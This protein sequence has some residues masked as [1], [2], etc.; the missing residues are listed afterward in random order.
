MTAVAV[1]CSAWLAVIGWSDEVSFLHFLVVG[2]TAFGILA[3]VKAMLD[4][5]HR[6]HLFGMGFN[7][8]ELPGVA[9]AV[10]AVIAGYGWLELLKLRCQ[11]FVV[12]LKL[13]YLGRKFR[14]LALE[15]RNL[16]L[17]HREMLGLDSRGAVLLDDFVDEGE[18]IKAHNEG[19][20]K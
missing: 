5:Q 9:V 20:A 10:R 15:N 17:Q 13:F 1:L 11:F 16:V 8:F 19:R 14:R 4:A 7:F 18:W 6:E 3:L 12:R 2:L